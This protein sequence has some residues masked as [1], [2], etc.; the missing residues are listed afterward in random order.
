MNGVVEKYP[1]AIANTT[2]YSNTT[3]GVPREDYMHLFRDAA[4]GDLPWPG[5]VG[6]SI[7][8][9]WYWCSD[10][11]LTLFPKDRQMLLISV[12]EFELDDDHKH[13]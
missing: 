12:S 4:T 5:I 10:Q 7:N 13:C 2:K 3:C 6:M 9:I 11:V 8:S 1:H